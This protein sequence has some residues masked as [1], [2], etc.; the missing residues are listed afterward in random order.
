MPQ[1][2]MECDA[3][4]Q[5]HSRI[6]LNN[7]SSSGFLRAERHLMLHVFN[8][9]KIPLSRTQKDRSYLRLS[10]ERRM[11]DTGHRVELELFGTFGNLGHHFLYEVYTDWS[12]LLMGVLSDHPRKIQY[13]NCMFATGSQLQSQDSWTQIVM[14]KC[15]D[16]WTHQES[17]TMQKRYVDLI[18]DRPVYGFEHLSAHRVHWSFLNMVSEE[19]TKDFGRIPKAIASYCSEVLILIMIWLFP[20]GV[21]IVRDNDRMAW[22]QVWVSPTNIDFGVHSGELW[23][24]VH[25]ARWP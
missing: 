13:N 5:T 2:G 8:R 3:P 23:V 19:T 7:G 1:K 17:S 18:Y 20:L 25:M 15:L 21:C 14:R 24:L 9:P 22:R 16:L 12:T 10:S 4:D 6:C 11:R